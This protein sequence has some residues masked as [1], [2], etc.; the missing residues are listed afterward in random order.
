M[1]LSTVVS[2]VFELAAVSK[3][4][5]PP[6]DEAAGTGVALGTGNTSLIK[7]VQPLT[8]KICLDGAIPLVIDLLFRMKIS[9]TVGSP[10]AS[11]GASGAADHGAC[12]EAAALDHKTAALLQENVAA[13]P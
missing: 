6:D 12:P 7:M 3:D 8:V 9:A 11:A 4:V 10:G 13:C 1:L 2:P 5:P